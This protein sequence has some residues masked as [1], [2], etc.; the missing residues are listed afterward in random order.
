MC[1]PIRLMDAVRRGWENRGLP[2]TN[3]RF[4]T[5]GNS[6][7]WA[8]Q[9]FVVRIPRLG[10]ETRV[11]ANATMLEALE[12]AGVEMMFDCRKG[13][14]GLCQ[15]SVLGLDGQLD[16]RDVF[17]SDRQ[18]QTGTSMCC[19]VSRVVSAA[20]AADPGERPAAVLTI[21]VP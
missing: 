9:D 3:L 11:D 1:G 10:V 17:Y 15:V 4:E 20:P 19:C 2:A 7:A 18:K 13:E 21:D 5:F 8:P 6:G 16:H 14:C 12:R